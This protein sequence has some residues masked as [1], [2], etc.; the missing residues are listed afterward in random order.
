VHGKRAFDEL[1]HLPLKREIV[2]VGNGEKIELQHYQ[3]FILL[4]NGIIRSAVK[5]DKHVIFIDFFF[6]YL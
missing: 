5:L 4:S 2:R 3:K 6:T 1:K